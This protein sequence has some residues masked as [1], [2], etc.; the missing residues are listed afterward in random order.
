MQI[1]E[2][3]RQLSSLATCKVLLAY[4]PFGDEVDVEPFLLTHLGAGG[5]VL[6]PRVAGERLEV[7]PVGRLDGL[8]PGWRGVLEPVDSPVSPEIIQ[9]ALIPGVGFDEQ[10]HR[11]GYGGGHFDRL[12]AALA[13]SALRVG[14]AF[15]AQVLWRLPVEA[16][17]EPVQ[18]LVTETGPRSFS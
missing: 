7:A 6:L 8:V 3:L 16:H 17:D 14:V 5:T 12:L 15:D 18:L 9:A 13:P 10:G 11:L 2:H 1:V 4:A